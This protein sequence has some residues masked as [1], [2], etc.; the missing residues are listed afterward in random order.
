MINLSL[1]FNY[2]CCV[3]GLPR[4]MVLVTKT[5]HTEG[6]KASFEHTERATR[7]QPVWVV[8]PGRELRGRI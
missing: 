3:N 6:G 4:S 1:I 7:D 8:V 5:R 2:F